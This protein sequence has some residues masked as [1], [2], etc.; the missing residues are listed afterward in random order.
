MKG[1]FLGDL[2]TKRE[3]YASF[4]VEKGGGKLQSEA[5]PRVSGKGSKRILDQV[6]FRSRRIQNLKNVVGVF[7][8]E[9]LDWERSS[10]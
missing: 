5:F 8:T 1:S 3:A 9:I 10:L 7:L 2:C 6:S 4:V